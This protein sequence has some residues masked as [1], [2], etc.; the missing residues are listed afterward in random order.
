MVLSVIE[1]IAL[2]SRP[3]TSWRSLER[4]ADQS[5]TPLVTNE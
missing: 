5:E 3:L 1:R 2:P 4:W